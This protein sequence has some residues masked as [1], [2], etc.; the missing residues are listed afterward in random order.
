MYRIALLSSSLIIRC[1]R[2]VSPSLQTAATSLSSR[3]EISR[4]IKTN[5]T[6]PRHTRVLFSPIHRNSDS[7]NMIDA[8]VGEGEVEA[9]VGI[10]AYSNNLPGFQGILKQ[11]YSD[12]VVREVNCDDEVLF[13]QDL[14]GSE[15]EKQY[16]GVDTSNHIS[17]SSSSSSDGATSGED[18][19]TK[20]DQFIT[21]I[22]TTVESSTTPVVGDISAELK[23][24][25]EYIAQAVVDISSVPPSIVTVAANDKPVR[26]AIHQLVRSHLGHI[27][28]S[29]TVK[30][31]S[32]GAQRIRIYLKKQVQKQGSKDKRDNNSSS[33]DNSAPIFYRAKQW[34]VG[35]G[36][37]LKFTMVKYNVDTLSACSIVGKHLRCKP[38]EGFDFA[39]TKDKR[40]VTIQQCTMYRR[41]P[42]ELMRLNNFHNPPII[43]FGDFKYCNEKLRLGQ[44]RGNR[45]TIAL[46]KVSQ[47]DETIFAACRGLAEGGFINYFG[48][49]RFGFGGSMSHRIGLAAYKSE[50][51]R[52]I[53]LLFAPRD[54]ER[55]ELARAKEFATQGKYSLALREIPHSFIAEKAVL[56]HLMK[57]NNDFYGAF[58]R[59]PRQ[60]R[61]LCAHAY[62]SMV[63]NK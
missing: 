10:T 25:R 32:T 5:S 8:L 2:P 45:F 49:Q 59:M 23:K 58:D 47:D 17:S 36:D 50:W 43:R 12:F 38:G 41:R 42:S 29:D 40:A 39:G 53:E 4:A 20:V 56:Q 7:D 28:E 54:G 46:R 14:S 60:T 57:L 9:A 11:R 48:L 61:I 63:W 31:E 13:L 19:T 37:F 3:L 34:P 1:H 51:K 44:L 24:L 26:G 35:L 21:N 30:D 55:D 18:V 62:Q 6:A 16:F 15:L 52:A 33:R 27:A 22:R